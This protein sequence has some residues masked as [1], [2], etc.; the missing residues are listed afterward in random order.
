[1]GTSIYHR[2]HDC[3]FALSA[4]G[5]SPVR[6]FNRC[7]SEAKER[8]ACYRGKHDAFSIVEFET[9]KRRYLHLLHQ[10]EVYWKKRSKQF[11]LSEGDAKNPLLSCNDDC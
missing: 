6:D 3:G 7:V 10:K 8:M 11:W 9:A 4:W 1:M 5:A 2:I